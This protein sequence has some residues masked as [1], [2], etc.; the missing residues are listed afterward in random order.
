[1][2]PTKVNFDWSNSEIGWK[3]ANGR[4]LICT[5]TVV[6]YLFNKLCIIEIFVI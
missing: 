2:C 1:M 3:M 4:M 6:L 5:L